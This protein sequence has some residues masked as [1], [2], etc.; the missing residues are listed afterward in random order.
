MTFLPS[1]LSFLERL[2]L[3]Q[4]QVRYHNIRHD[5]LTCYK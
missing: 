5:M 2:Y 1:K 4:A 3:N